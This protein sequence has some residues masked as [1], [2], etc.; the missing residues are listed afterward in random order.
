MNNSIPIVIVAAA[1]M[2]ETKEYHSPPQIYECAESKQAV[3]D[4]DLCLS[5]ISHRQQDGSHLMEVVSRKNRHGPEF[6]FLIKM[7]IP[8]GK[9]DEIWDESLIDD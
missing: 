9:I 7:D 6:N 4:V 3:F 5:L 8:N 1:S 2:N